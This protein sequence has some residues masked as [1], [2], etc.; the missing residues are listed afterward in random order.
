MNTAAGV[1]RV[2]WTLSHERLARAVA[3]LGADV[4]ALQEVDHLLPRT[5]SVEVGGV[6]LTELPGR[7]AEKTT[8]GAAKGITK[9]VLDAGQETWREIREERKEKKR[10]K[11]GG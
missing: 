2:A 7:M 3:D 9:G 4:L 11:R 10:R 6:G 1:D 5:G 8:Q